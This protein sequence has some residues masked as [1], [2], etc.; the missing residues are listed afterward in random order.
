MEREQAYKDAA[1]HYE[2]AWKHENQA[3]AQVRR[4]HHH[5]GYTM[6]AVIA[7]LWRWWS[8]MRPGAWSVGWS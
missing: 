8:C 2:K 6:L 3:S 5:I 7:Y 4:P 1:D